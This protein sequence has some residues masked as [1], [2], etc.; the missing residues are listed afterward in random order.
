[1]E[2]ILKLAGN[3]AMNKIIDFLAPVILLATYILG[4]KTGP[5]LIHWLKP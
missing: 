3:A 5:M 1:M 4:V 2:T